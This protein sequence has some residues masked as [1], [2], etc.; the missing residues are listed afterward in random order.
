MEIL[1]K[2]YKLPNLCHHLFHCLPS[3]CPANVVPWPHPYKSPYQPISTKPN[4]LTYLLSWL[5]LSL[6]YPGSKLSPLALHSSTWNVL[7]FA[8]H[9]FCMFLPFSFIVSIPLSPIFCCLKACHC[10]ICVWSYLK[11]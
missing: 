11:Q 4:L 6:M 8:I 9:F 3:P 7:N 5:G 1:L 2:L 10:A